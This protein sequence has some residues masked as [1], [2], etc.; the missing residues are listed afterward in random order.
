MAISFTKL[1]QDG[2]IDASDPNNY[3]DKT[4]DEHTFRKRLLNFA[5]QRELTAG[6]PGLVKEMMLLF[7]S[8][9]KALHNCRNDQERKD[10]AKLF[11]VQAYK[12]IDSDGHLVV[13][14]EIVI[15]DKS[16]LDNKI[17]L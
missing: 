13:D 5:R 4:L 1:N 6:V 9:D 16:K 11:V 8:A 3:S 10:M 2:N 7:I 15:T 12:I 14:G 17:I